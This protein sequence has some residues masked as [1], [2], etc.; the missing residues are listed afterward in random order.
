MAT[1]DA[2][3]TIAPTPTPEAV[4][5]EVVKTA[6][7]GEKEAPKPAAEEPMNAEEPA[8][9]P[10][11]EAAADATPTEET[12][13]VEEPT[14]PFKEE[15]NVVADLKESEKKAL[16]EFK[17]RIVKA[18][19][20]NEFKVPKKVVEPPPKEPE[21]VETPKEAEAPA[22][23]TSAAETPA[24]TTET[25]VAETPAAEAK[26]GEA[27]AAET[28]AAEAKEVETPAGEAKEVATPAAE[29]S[30]PVETAA[31]VETPVVEAKEAPPAEPAGESGPAVTTEETPAA[32]TEEAVVE[33][34]DAPVEESAPPPA[35]TPA[36]EEEEEDLTPPED[37]SLW[38]VPLLPSK[39]DERTD[40][41]LLKFLRARDFNVALAFE[42]LKKTI[43]WR[44]TFKADKL[45]EEDFGTDFDAVAF[46]DGK[47][48][49]GHPVCYNVYSPFQDKELYAKAF[50][51]P[52]KLANFIR[53]RIQV[54]EKSLKHLTFSPEGP[55]AL[56][57]IMD[58]KHFPGPGKREV[59]SAYN[60]AV[61]ILQ[62]NYPELTVK[63]VFINVPW[64]YSALYAFVSPFLSA[65]TKSKFSR[66]TPGRT[67]EGLLKFMSADHIPIA[68]GGLSKPNDPDFTGVEAPTADLA[69]KA[70]EK[71]TI[72]IPVT[73]VSGTVVWELSVVGYDVIYGA[74]YVPSAE[75]SYTTILEK[76]K[77]LPSTTEEP[78]RS[79]FKVS[80]PGKIVINLE[81]P[82]RRKKIAIYRYTVKTPAAE[83]EVS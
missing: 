12:A 24:E 36:V 39:G 56:V 1:P 65:R 10:T 35:E 53:W 67:T 52:T 73:E 42:Q 69:I 72:E 37:V 83:T 4:V 5:A 71:A 7:S 27:P 31:A 76:P 14:V 49:D 15:S 62:D 77:K 68:Y 33:A 34:K 29:T 28:P 60:Q 30:T 59:R 57:Q 18:I 50:G 75:G 26:E 40:V 74:E 58:L 80:E 55:S 63:M 9:A 78:L 44:K 22:A 51:D 47:D 20:D 17:A 16:E 32:S 8:A 38:G 6:E 48:K 3:E 54:L 61:N 41:I 43:I 66:F 13:H 82:G 64:Y 45:L 21:V 79:S 19:A 25:P 46:D 23:E 11:D 70:S 2:E 81:N